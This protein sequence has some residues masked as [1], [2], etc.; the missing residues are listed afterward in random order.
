MIARHT[1]ISRGALARAETF[2]R[3]HLA[4]GPVQS[5]VIARKGAEAG[6][7]RRTLTAAKYN[8]AR[9]IR[10]DG[11]YESTDRSGWYMEL[12]GDSADDSGA[13]GTDMF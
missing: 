1:P 4:N 11:D 3:K 2:L 9:S 8:V 10:P 13:P 12:T 5:V 6:I 7:P